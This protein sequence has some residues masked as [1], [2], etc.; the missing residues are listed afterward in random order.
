MKD[1]MSLKSFLIL[2]KTQNSASINAKKFFLFGLNFSDST[3]A[4]EWAMRSVENYVTVPLPETFEELQKIPSDKTYNF[5]TSLDRTSI[6]KETARLGV[7]A[8]MF[9]ELSKVEAALNAFC[10]QWFVNDCKAYMKE[11]LDSTADT[12]NTFTSTLSPT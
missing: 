8:L 11:T 9:W 3:S 12:E 7:E 6:D 4:S 10:K 5:I 2:Y 1:S